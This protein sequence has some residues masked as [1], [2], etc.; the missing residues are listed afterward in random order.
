MVGRSDA[1]EGAL[2]IDDR[3][4]VRP[5]DRLTVRPPDRPTAYGT[6]SCHSPLSMSIA[7]SD[8]P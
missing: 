7:Y 6:P 1:G 5:S 3:P 8:P 2:L 4:T